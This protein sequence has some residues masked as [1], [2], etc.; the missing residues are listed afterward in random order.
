LIARPAVLGAIVLAC[1]AAAALAVFGSLRPAP[2]PI[3]SNT[4]HRGNGA[5]AESLD[6]QAARSE[7]ALTI[8][9]D[10]YE[11][12]TSIDG[13]GR[14]VLAAADRYSVSEDGRRYTFH[15]RPGLRWSNGE[16][17]IAEDFAFSW[18]RLVDPATAAP[19]AQMLVPVRNA[20][21][22]IA[23]AQPAASLGVQA[24]DPA[25]LEVELA[26][27]APYF[28]NVL[29][30]PGTFPLHRAS[31][32]AFGGRFAKPGVMVSNGAYGLLRWDFGSKIVLARNHHYWNDANTHIDRVEYH[33]IAQSAAELNAYRSGQLDCTSSVATPQ[34]P[35]VRSQLGSQLHVS[36]QLA[37]YYYGLN[38]RTA[39]FADR[40]KLRLALSMVIDRERLVSAVTGMGELPAYG[41]V[42]PQTAGFTA[43]TPEFAR[44]PMAVRIARARELLRE[45]GMQAPGPIELRYNTGDL[46]TAIAVAVASMWKDALGLETRLHGEE[47]KVLLQDI[48]RADVTQV[49]R[50]S[51]V[52][53]YNDAYN[54]L[55]LL[56]TGFG[57]NLPRYSNPRYDQLL[58]QANAQT[59]PLKR[60]AG[61]EE[62][63]RAM[64]A[65]QPV[66][67]LYF[68]VNKHLV[69]P[70]VRGWRDNVMNIIYSKDLSLDLTAAQ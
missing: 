62:A 5:E 16:P 8:A 17:V 47:F 53:D 26:R 31:L 46:H 11:G 60:R 22:I 21:A 20:S 42:P 4:L 9:R 68:Y 41:F 40:R 48:D 43:Q 7:A 15:L 24:P 57:I 64:L 12:L 59:D 35:I 13:S 18:R 50:A 27:P 25:T 3:R 49:F 1:A 29:A 32:A 45:S 10:L 33:S 70:R 56:R 61:L 69:K 38:L 67:P 30:H 44:W 6:P 52:A 28:L 37:V 23:G 63:E 54:F 14:A 39:P 36:P 34:L 65:D 55:Q 19:Y 66:I 58:D 51:W 2:D